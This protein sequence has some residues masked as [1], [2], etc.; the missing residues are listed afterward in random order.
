MI[1]N[2]WYIACFNDELKKNSVLNRKI[3]GEE[4]VIFKNAKGEVSILED[5]CCHRNVHL[6]LGHVEGDH[7]KCGYHGWKYNTNGKCVHIP[8]IEDSQKI[9]TSAC[10]KKYTFQ[11]KHQ[12]YW[13]YIGDENMIDEAEIPN[14]EALDKHR[15]VHNKH[16]LKANIKLVAESLFDAQHLNHVHRKSIKTLLGKLREPKTEYDIDIKEKSLFGQYKRINNSSIFEKI[17][18]GWEKHLETKFAYWFPH[19]SLLDSHFPKHLHFPARRLVIYEHFYEIDEEHVMMMQITAWKN[20]F[21]FNPWFA[22][23]FMKQKS[24]TIVGED[25]AFLES[26][27]HWHEKRSLQDLIIKN[28]EPTISF[29]KLWNNNIKSSN[30]KLDK[31][32]A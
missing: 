7:I 4:I 21:R 10:I 20:I 26:N 30:E 18:F 11:F 28:D 19:T 25:I 12:A 13:V 5:R 15:F 17:Y 22:R 6:S 24:D 2:Q 3:V 16:I 29:M 32:E 1:K 31:K 14:L 9:P 23:W 27:R 8:M